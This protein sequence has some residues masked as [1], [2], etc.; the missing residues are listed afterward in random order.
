MVQSLN[1]KQYDGFIGVLG[2]RE[3]GLLDNQK[4]SRNLHTLWRILH[5][6]QGVRMIVEQA[7]AV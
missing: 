6:Q 7:A 4:K 2:G 1:N 3:E 5:V